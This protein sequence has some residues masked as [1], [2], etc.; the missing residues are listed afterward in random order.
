MTPYYFGSCGGS[1]EK[2][3]SSGRDRV[4]HRPGSHD[5]RANAL[6]GVVSLLTKRRRDLSGMDLDIRADPGLA[7]ENGFEGMTAADVAT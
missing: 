6:T 3:G 4:D 1:S 7:V 2:R 5:D